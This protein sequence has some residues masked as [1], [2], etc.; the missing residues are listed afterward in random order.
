MRPPLVVEV[1]L[2]AALLWVQ[3]GRLW[4][5]ERIAGDAF[6]AWA[7]GPWREVTD[8]APGLGGRVLTQ[9]EVARLVAPYGVEVSKGTNH[10]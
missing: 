6:S 9:D 4:A 1:L 8:V 10:E 5:C 2:G 7:Y 3:H